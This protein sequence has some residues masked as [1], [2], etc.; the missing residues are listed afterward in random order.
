[1]NYRVISLIIALS[2]SISAVA[3]QIDT[4]SFLHITDLHIIFNQAGYHPAMIDNRLSKN[5]GTGEPRLKEF[6][7]TVPKQTNSDLVIATGDLCDFFEGPT[8]TGARMALQA[9]QLAQLLGESKV[10]VLL[11]LGNHDAFYFYWQED[12]LKHDQNATGRAHAAWIRNIS[13]FRDGVYYSRIYQVGTTTYRLIFLDDMF[14]KFRSEIEADANEV[15][16]MDE[17]QLAWLTDQLNAS[18]E[19]VE[20]ILMHIPFPK[21]V[22]EQTKPNKLLKVLA[23]EPSVKL[24]VGGHHH[25]NAIDVIA[26]AAGSNI[27]QVQTAAFAVNSEHWRQIKL[28]EDRITVS[29]PGK[30]NKQVVNINLD[31]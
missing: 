14:Y 1:M 28:T 5:Y 8:P 9:E 17:A 2:A 13:C 29:A 7:Q 15:P 31:K 10:P 24:I 4:L 26:T 11:T 23:S 19:D 30:S 25:K 6:L 12:K 16:Y 22:I 21:A 27:I 18:D 3:Q 20:I